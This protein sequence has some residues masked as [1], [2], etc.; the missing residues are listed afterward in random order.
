[1]GQTSNFPV[2]LYDSISIGIQLNC[3]FFPEK[4]QKLIKC[5]GKWKCRKMS[6]FYIRALID[7][8]MSHFRFNWSILFLRLFRYN[9]IRQHGRA[10]AA[11]LFP[12]WVEWLCEMNKWSAHVKTTTMGKSDGWNT[13]AA[14]ATVWQI[15]RFV[16]NLWQRL[17]WPSRSHSTQSVWHRAV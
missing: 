8:R 3:V 1:M 2:I 11:H 17:A 9:A 16:H 6:L 15:Y 10:R 7:R 5:S 12:S 13:V 14:V 4:G